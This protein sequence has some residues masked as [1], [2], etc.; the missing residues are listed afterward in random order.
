MRGECGE[1]QVKKLPRTTMLRGYG[2]SQN[3][4]SIILKTKD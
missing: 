1:R 3:V 2:G 4:C